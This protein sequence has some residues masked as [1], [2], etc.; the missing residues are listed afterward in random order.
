MTGG[1]F[2]TDLVAVRFITE[3]FQ[4]RQF[5]RAAAIV[6]VLMLATIPVMIY[7]IRQFRAQEAR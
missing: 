1:N 5:G 2:D 7:N 3:L 6:V 4:F